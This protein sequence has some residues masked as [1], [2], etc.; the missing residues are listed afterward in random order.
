M[1][2][3]HGWLRGLRGG[4]LA[5]CCLLLGLSGHALGG[6]PLGLTAPVLVTG[7]LIA[8]GSVACAVR[9]R[10][11]GQLFAAAACSQLAFHLA[12][13]LSPEPSM[14]AHAAFDSRMLLAH[15]GGAVPLAAVLAR[16][17]AAFWALYRAARRFVLPLVASTVPVVDRT[18][19]VGALSTA[20][21]GVRARLLVSAATP[22]RGPPQECAA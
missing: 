16:G 7:A 21:V 4:V 5:V 13:S 15:A 18:P 9:Q 20:P 10:D 19:L 8:A 12:L 3:G 14:G 17:D 11:F 1:N 6:A 22:Y 2:P